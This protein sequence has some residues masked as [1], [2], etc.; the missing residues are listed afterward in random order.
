MLSVLGWDFLPSSLLISPPHSSFSPPRDDEEHITDNVDFIPRF[1]TLENED[2][3]EP[4]SLPVFSECES[5]TAISWLTPKSSI[6]LHQYSS[7]IRRLAA[8]WI[9]T[10]LPLS[11]R[12]CCPMLNSNSPVTTAHPHGILRRLRL[13]S[14]RPHWCPSIQLRQQSV[15]TVLPCIPLQRPHFPFQTCVSGFHPCM[16]DILTIP[17]H[18]L[19]FCS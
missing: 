11:S 16:R 18:I 12:P 6:L 1:D 8:A 19:F 17:P 10:K 3:D 4:H 9:S 2:G 15:F 14:T 7:Y 13:F 5:L